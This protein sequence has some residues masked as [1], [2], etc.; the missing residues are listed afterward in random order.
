MQF[1]IRLDASKLTEAL[2]EAEDE[3]VEYLTLVITGNVDEK[4]GTTINKKY[5]YGR[6]STDYLRDI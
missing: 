6:C 3:G 4:K 5:L 2:V 1:E